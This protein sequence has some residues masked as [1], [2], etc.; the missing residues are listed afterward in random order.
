MNELEQ[1]C[2]PT[3]DQGFERLLKAYNA[4]LMNYLR[5]KYSRKTFDTNR[6]M[7]YSQQVWLKVWANREAFCARSERNFR[8]WL[9]QIGENEVLQDIRK[10]RPDAIP[11]SYNQADDKLEDPAQSALEGEH[12]LALNHELSL[13]F[14][15]N[16]LYCCLE[17]LKSNQAHLFDALVSKQLGEE[18]EEAVLNKYKI[19][20]ATLSRW[21]WIASQKVGTCMSGATS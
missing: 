4:F 8:A 1:F 16:R 15:N 5:S 7:D 21:R 2:G 3:P 13:E 19:D 17:Q 11:E 18:A 6:L 20:R 9:F 12:R 14:S 10:K